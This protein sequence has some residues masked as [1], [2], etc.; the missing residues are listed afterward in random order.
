MQKRPLCFHRLRKVPQQCS[1][2]DQRLVRDGHIEHLSHAACTRSLCL[3]TVADA[4]GLSVSADL[5][6][7][8]RV[9]LEHPAV[10]TARQGLIQRDLVAYDTPLSQVFALEAQAGNRLPHTPSMSTADQPMA[11]KD[12]FTH[13]AATLR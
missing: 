11:L 10:Y 7:C 6:V 3:V 1:W 8:R 2:G 5:S 4:Q 13:R 9:S 12:I